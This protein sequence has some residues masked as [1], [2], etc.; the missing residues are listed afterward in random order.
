MTTETT[1]RTAPT[2]RD[3]RAAVHA[4][5]DLM[6]QHETLPAAY[7]T[8]HDHYAGG[9]LSKVDMQ[10]EGWQEFEAWRTELEI[11][12]ADVE[13]HVTVSNAWLSADTSHKG[14][15]VHLCGFGLSL[16]AAEFNAPRETSEVAA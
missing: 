3:Q 4:I 5:A 7:I 2:I 8:I 1:A 15:R 16:S 9:S 11:P 14:I 6:A 13:L 12:P 10:F